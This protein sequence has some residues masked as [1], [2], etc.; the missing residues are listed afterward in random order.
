MS[1]LCARQRGTMLRQE[2]SELVNII[3]WTETMGLSTNLPIYLPTFRTLLRFSGL[4]Q[5]TELGYLG[6]FYLLDQK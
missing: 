6:Q 3:V 1:T 2:T 4:D 5:G